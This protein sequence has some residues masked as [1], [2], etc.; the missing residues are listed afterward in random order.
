MRAARCRSSS[1]GHAL[2]RVTVPPELDLHLAARIARERYRCSLSL[3]WVEGSDRF[4]LGGDEAVARRP[5]DVGSM[6]EHLAAK[7]LWVTALPDPDHVARLRIA[8]AVEK[9]ERIDE[10]VTEIAMGRSLLEG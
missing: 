10:V 4:V 5:L 6:V 2:V 3:S 9:P 7:F 8:G 1:G